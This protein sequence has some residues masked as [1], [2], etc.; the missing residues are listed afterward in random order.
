MSGEA[1]DGARLVAFEGVDGAGKSTVLESLRV[2]L[3]DRGKDVFVIG[4]HSWADPASARVL[5]AMREQRAEV[6]PPLVAEAYRRDKEGW[7]HYVER[8][9]AAGMSVMSDRYAL[10]DVVYLHCLYDLPVA[11]LVERYRRLRIARPH[12][13][14]LVK[15]PPDLAYERVL[16]RGRTLRFYEHRD[17]LR[18]AA[19]TFDELLTIEDLAPDAL[20]FDN[21]EP[22]TEARVEALADELFGAVTAPRA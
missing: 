19:A 9:L 22:L 13:T 10:G 7:G 20:V 12:R 14:V 18:R 8:A 21:A 17:F 5:I 6:A 1:S 2:A 3:L 15:V 11:R 16:A 4:G